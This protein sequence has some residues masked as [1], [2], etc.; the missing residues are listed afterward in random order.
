MGRRKPIGG[1]GCS[2]SIRENQGRQQSRPRRRQGSV[3]S[4]W[5]WLR[6]EPARRWRKGKMLKKTKRKKK[7]VQKEEA[8]IKGGEPS[9]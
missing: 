9:Q 5:F 1:L 7:I 8:A 3:G 2:L 6:C 4:K